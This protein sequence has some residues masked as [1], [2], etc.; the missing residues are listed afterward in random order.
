LG[1]YATSASKSDYINVPEGTTVFD[2]STG[3]PV[4]TAPKSLSSTEKTATAA[5]LK[6]TETARQKN[7]DAL[8]VIKEIE[9][10][11][12]KVFGLNAARTWLPGTAP[13]TFGKKVT[14]LKNLLTLE[15]MPLMKGVLS[16]SDMKVL[17]GAATALDVTMAESDFNTELAL[18]K[19][20][21]Q[22]GM[23]KLEAATMDSDPLGLG[24]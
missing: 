21:L 12:G 19:K 22:T 3:Q 18:I 8:A 14:Q 16:D 13:Y 5:Q 20:K 10:S 17:S 2:P 9:D 7:E 1:D 11:P 24:I 23:A 15:Y 6:D 4:Y